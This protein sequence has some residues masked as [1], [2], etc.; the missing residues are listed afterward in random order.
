MDP[1]LA[2]VDALCRICGEKIK[3]GKGYINA[4]KVMDYF[5][6]LRTYGITPAEESKVSVFF[7]YFKFCTCDEMFIFVVKKNSVILAILC[8]PFW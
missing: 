8:Q 5:D 7:F 4:K 3:F 2:L 6:I 1:H